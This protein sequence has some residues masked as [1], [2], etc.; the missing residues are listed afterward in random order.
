MEV[1]LAL[2][3]SA[4]VLAGVGGVFYSAIRLRD[5]TASMVDESVSL[6]QALNFLRRDLLG[7]LPPAGTYALAGDFKSEQIGGGIGQ[8]FRL[9]FFTSTG[10][11]KDST[12]WGE[13][14]EV[15]YELRDPI[16]RNGAPGREL[17]RS[18]YR[19]LLATA[20]QEPEEQFLLGNVQSLE[21]SCYDGY[22]WRESWT[23]V[24]AIR[25]CPQPFGFAFSSQMTQEAP[26][27]RSNLLRWSSP[28]DAIADESN[29]EPMKSSN[30]QQSSAREAPNPRFGAYCLDLLSS[31]NVGC[32]SLGRRVPSRPQERGSTFVIVLWIAF[33]LVSMA[34]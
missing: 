22:D 2:V 26:K 16:T 1:M 13:I 5:R 32:W 11:I 20:I 17:I 4:I 8:N 3:V 7:A 21:F 28:G 30:L 18:V 23:R 31:L 27:S 24:S 34:L 33:G 14:Q 15:S 25:T 29:S 12:S 19:N 9:Q 6:H 10:V